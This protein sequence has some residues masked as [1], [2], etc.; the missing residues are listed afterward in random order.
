MQFTN[1]FPSLILHPSESSNERQALK[2]TT[3][4]QNQRDHHGDVLKNIPDIDS[5]NAKAESG[6][7]NELSKRLEAKKPNKKQVLEGKQ[8][9]EDKM[10]NNLLEDDSAVEYE[11]L[12][13]DGDMR[14][15]PMEKANRR[16]EQEA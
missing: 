11:E 8:E 10:P 1:Q 3:L 7:R 12:I 4:E 13:E 15:S 14:M 16:R 2:R 6:K 5:L 9:L